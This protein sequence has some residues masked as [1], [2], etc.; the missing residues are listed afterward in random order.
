MRMQLVLAGQQRFHLADVDLSIRAAEQK[1]FRSS[2]EKFRRTAFVGLKVSM[3]VADHALERLAQL[4][5]RQRVRCRAGENKINIAVGLEDFT[6]PIARARSPPVL[7]IGWRVMG[8]GFLQC[9]PSLRANRCD[10]IARKFMALY[11][12]LACLL[13][14]FLR[15]INQHKRD[16]LTAQSPGP[17]NSARQISFD[18]L[19]KSRAAVSFLFSN[20]GGQVSVSP[21]KIFYAPKTRR[22]R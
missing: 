16:C 4:R 14:E 17:P 21:K 6:D 13:R 8:I 19:F 1:E 12:H 5:E 11:D 2:G 7:A 10:V 20:R 3:L 22:V 18:L 9:G 15:R